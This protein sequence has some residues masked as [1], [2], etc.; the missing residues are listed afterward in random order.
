MG[1]TSWA[2]YFQPVWG[3]FSLGAQIWAEGVNIGTFSLCEIK[4]F[5]LPDRIPRHIQR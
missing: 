1:M 2:A 4:L 5:Q 3:T